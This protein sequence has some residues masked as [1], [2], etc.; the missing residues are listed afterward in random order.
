MADDGRGK[1]MSRRRTPCRLHR[2]WR[3]RRDAV[4]AFRHALV[5]TL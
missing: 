2:V 1:P 4:A 5:D 3:R